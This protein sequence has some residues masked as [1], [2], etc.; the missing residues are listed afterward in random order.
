MN[1][2][3]KMKESKFHDLEIQLDRS[4]VITSLLINDVVLSISFSVYIKFFR[5]TRSEIERSAENWR[6]KKFYHGRNKTCDPSREHMRTSPSTERM[7]DAHIF[8]CVL[9]WCC[10]CSKLVIEKSSY[11]YQFII[12]E[13]ENK[14]R[15]MF[16]N[17][18]HYIFEFLNCFAVC[19][20]CQIWCEG[21]RT[22]MVFFYMISRIG[23]WRHWQSTLSSIN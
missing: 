21:C 5:S 2:K 8:V 18:Y 1:L 12:F 15:K 14:I 20:L 23:R 22:L 4:D 13:N 19:R 11:F 3:K 6:S 7:T 16:E 17:Y 10:C 9:L